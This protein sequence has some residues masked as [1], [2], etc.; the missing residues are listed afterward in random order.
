MFFLFFCRASSHS[1]VFF[2]KKIVLL[3][4]S[5]DHN[6]LIALLLAAGSGSL[7]LVLSADLL[8]TVLALLALL[9]GD[10]LLLEQSILQRKKK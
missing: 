9:A 5:D 10:L 8:G 4:Y 7:V 6:Q 1:C 3:P 2:C